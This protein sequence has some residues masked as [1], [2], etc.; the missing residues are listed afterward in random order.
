MPAKVKKTAAR[1]TQLLFTAAEAAAAAATIAVSASE[2]FGYSDDIAIASLLSS[3]VVALTVF[4]FSG[5]ATYR[6]LLH[7]FMGDD[8][9][10][11]DE[12]STITT[13]PT[14]WSTAGY[15]TMH[16][17][18]VFIFL[19]YNWLSLYFLAGSTKT[20]FMPSQAIVDDS[21]E[22]HVYQSLSRNEL[23]IVNALYVFVALPFIVTNR[24]WETSENLQQLFNVED[25]LA[26]VLKRLFAPLLSNRFFQ[27]Y[28]RYVGSL[29]HTLEHILPMFIVHMPATVFKNLSQI[30]KQLAIS[31]SSFLSLVIGLPIFGETVLFDARESLE[32]MQSV[33]ECHELLAFDVS[34]LDLSNEQIRQTDDLV[35]VLKRCSAQAQEED[36]SIDDILL[37][38][39]IEQLDQVFTS[40]QQTDYSLSKLFESLQDNTKV[41]L[42]LFIKRN[43]NTI[44]PDKLLTPF[45][46]SVRSI[47]PLAHGY[48][49]VMPIVQCGRYF[50]FHAI[51]TYAAAT[52]AGLFS[53]VGNYWS[54]AH[55]SVE[56]I[57]QLQRLRRYLD[58]LSTP[59]ETTRL[60]I[61]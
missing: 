52:G 38:L 19:S 59:H 20:Y 37:S 18:Y 55:E 53:A 56:G 12:A 3:L 17:S 51:P 34:K 48:D 58:Q 47:G 40:L 35:Q 1:S 60:F 24:I 26:G 14:W 54:E 31:I 15:Y 46:Y 13:D 49:T 9:N 11:T 41:Q 32:N 45:K 21:T 44:I 22:H 27:Q 25:K 30:G 5:A 39:T 23:I 29:E 4:S 61:Q 6:N 43:I 36:A 2:E 16:W 10:A 50:R 28:V 8:D 42:A 57:E 7:F 33:R